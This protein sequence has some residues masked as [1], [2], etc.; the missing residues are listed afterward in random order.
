M[1]YLEAASTKEALEFRS[2]RARQAEK[3]YYDICCDK[4]NFRRRN[5]LYEKILRLLG[6][7][8]QLMIEFSDRDAA[9]YNPDTDYFYESGFTDC[10]Y[11]IQTFCNVDNLKST[12]EA[13]QKTGI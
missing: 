8:K 2:E 13:V 7:N 6:K 1:T 12:I 4:L 3:A 10:L 5:E 11:F 9:M